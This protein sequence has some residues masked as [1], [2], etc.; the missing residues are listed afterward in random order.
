M[1][2][3]I[4]HMHSL[5]FDA[6]LGLLLLMVA[7]AAGALWLLGRRRRSERRSIRVKLVDPKK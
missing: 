5:R 2:A 1:E 3:L 7:V 6:G 4:R